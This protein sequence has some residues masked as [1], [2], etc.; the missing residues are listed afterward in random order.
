MRKSP[1]NG[2][3]PNK[4]LLNLFLAV[5]IVALAYTTFELAYHCLP[6]TGS[7][8]IT[9]KEGGLSPPP[10]NHRTHLLGGRPY[11]WA[12]PDTARRHIYGFQGTCVRHNAIEMN[13][14]RI[15]GNP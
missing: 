1:Y 9:H 10:C 12:T 6:H 7:E 4:P 11:G 15:T 8:G 2:D 5:G 13:L 3:F 14:R